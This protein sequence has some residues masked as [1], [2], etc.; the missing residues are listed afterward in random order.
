M[1]YQAQRTNGMPT[2]NSPGGPLIWAFGSTLPGH[3]AHPHCS[4]L[5][6]A[7]LCGRRA[8]RQQAWLAGAGPQQPCAPAASTC[9]QHHKPYKPC[10]LHARRPHGGAGRPRGAP[11][12][13]AR[14]RSQTLQT[15]RL[16]RG[17]L[18]WA[19]YAA[20]R[21]GRRRRAA[22]AARV[23]RVSC[24]ARCFRAWRAETQVHS[25]SAQYPSYQ[26]G[27]NQV[28]AHSQLSMCSVPGCTARSW[29]H[30]KSRHL[31]NGMSHSPFLKERKHLPIGVVLHRRLRPSAARSCAHSKRCARRRAWH[32][33]SCGAGRERWRAPRWPAG[34]APLG[35]PAPR[36]R[37]RD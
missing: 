33:A 20:G 9:A 5:T 7:L 21:A 1:P 6:A 10:G 25:P 4:A 11:A 8:C 13:S 34:G 26:L 15:L 17:L 22:H 30:S 31:A 19:R 27:G 29:Q 18:R 14:S 12:A 35:R 37:G 2:S 36:A 28:L 3:T 23:L 24:S 16:L 32:A